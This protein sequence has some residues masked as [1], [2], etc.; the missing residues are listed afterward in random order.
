[1][2]FSRGQW[3]QD[4]IKAIGGNPS[5]ISIEFVCGWSYF[6]IPS[7]TNNTPKYNLLAT[8][9]N[10]QGA[11]NFNSVG[12]K[13]YTSYD[14]GVQANASTLKNG[15]YNDLLNALINNN[16]TLLKNP[17]SAMISQL[18]K[19]GTGYHINFVVEGTKHLNDVSTYGESSQGGQAAAF[20]QTNDGSNNSVPS[21]DQILSK[22]LDPMFIGK[23]SIGII[24]VALGLYF[25][26]KGVSINVK[27]K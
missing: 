13:N 15:L 22:V 27:T 21:T 8:T 4:F 12:V 11:T 6:E 24:L 18:N 1:M 7:M 26:V 19:W 2:S 3:A 5:Q 16:E 9:Q 10:A 23:M 14:Q 17:S 25:L 20:P